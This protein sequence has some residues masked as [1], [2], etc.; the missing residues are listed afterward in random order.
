MVKSPLG[1]EIYNYTSTKHFMID[2]PININEKN[3]ILEADVTVEVELAAIWFSTI[4]RNWRKRSH[5]VI[6]AGEFERIASKDAC[7]LL[8]VLICALNVRPSTETYVYVQRSLTHVFS[9][10]REAE[11]KLCWQLL[12]ELEKSMPREIKDE[13]F[14]WVIVLH[15]LKKASE[16]GI[17]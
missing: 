1:N 15:G 16:S 17:Q 5:Y 10:S 3:S 9:H 8:Q 7:C 13:S 14:G 6:R 2:Q 4:S 11:D 12:A